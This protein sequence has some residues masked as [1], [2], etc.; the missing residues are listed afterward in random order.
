MNDAPHSSLQPFARLTPNTVLAALEEIG[1]RCDGRLQ[2]LNSFENRVYLVGLEDGDSRVAK[3]YR[4]DRWG[5][6]Q[7]L[8]EHAFAHEIAAAEIPL[9]AP[10]HRGT[11]MDPD[12]HA[13]DR[14]DSGRHEN[15][16]T[17]A[18][19][20]SRK[21][22]LPAPGN[23]STPDSLPSPGNIP[24]PDS[25]LADT[26]FESHGFYV[27]VYR[28]QGGRVPELDN[29]HQGPAMR[30]RIGQF[31]AR[32]HQVGARRGF[33]HRL[34][35]DVERAGWASI[36]RVIGCPWLPP[37]VRHNWEALARRCCELA[38][39]RLHPSLHQPGVAD[40]T[41]IRLHG[42]CH[43]GN[44]LWTEAHGPHFVDLDDCCSGPAM[45]DLWMIADAA[46]QQDA[47]AD[48]SN[49]VSQAM[50]ELLAGYELIRP[51]ERRELALVEP[52]RTLR[53]IRHSA[54]LAERW[55]DPAFPAAFPWFGSVR[56]WQGQIISLQEQLAQLQEGL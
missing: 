24:T 49:A 33:V 27:A 39:Q 30:E 2:A 29:I 21:S 10:L 23:L 32:I 26:L 56:Y 25:P 51:F 13:P 37:E 45:Q 19:A 12:R 8:E 31:I 35:L 18:S 14:H 22:G 5:R 15:A 17:A 4:P 41:Q 20:S 40:F 6:N 34:P 44:L 38:E 16:G 1:L 43:L 36:E 11:L 50:Q 42:D 48:G 46:G 52:L 3:F 55:E 53:I 47:E 9:A 54:W 7:L 28:R